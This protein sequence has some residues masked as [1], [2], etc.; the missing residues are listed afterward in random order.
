[1]DNTPTLIPIASGKGGVGKS[2]LAA[3]IGSS[4]A[5]SC[6]RTILVDLDRGGSILHLFLGL[7]NR[8]P[9]IGDF[10]KTTDTDLEQLLVPTDISNLMFLP[11]DGKMPFMANI[12]HVQKEKLISRLQML[13]ADYILL[14]LSAGTTYNTLDFFN[15]AHPGTIV[16]TPAPASV[17]RL[18]SFLKAAVLRKIDRM[19]ARNIPVRALLNEWCYRPIDRQF[20]AIDTL[21]DSVARVDP[22]AEKAIREFLGRFRPRVIFNNAEHPEEMH[23]ATQISTNLYEKLSIEVDFFGFIYHDPNANQAVENRT[24]YLLY[25]RDRPEAG[26]I[27]R[28]AERISGYY[29]R[30]VQD[31]AER[32][33]RQA[34]EDYRDISDLQ[35]A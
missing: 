23:L 14:D 17:M 15:S 10:L 19:A 31:S 5:Q 32:L 13:P 2:F 29:D 22:G 9:G 27:V 7:Q 34:W 20:P 21:L 33:R 11:G 16:T 1:M 35:S 25:A 4:L 8:Y 24:P 30:A 12:T 28:T 26:G 3:N 18:L 6:Y